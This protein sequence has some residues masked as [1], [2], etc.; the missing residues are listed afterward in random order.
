LR[1]Q[2]HITQAGGLQLCFT[3]CKL[4]DRSRQQIKALTRV[5]LWPVISSLFFVCVDQIFKNATK[6]SNSPSL[7]CCARLQSHDN[8]WGA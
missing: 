2:I 7:A 8:A 5:E 6:N 3:H 4:I 1:P